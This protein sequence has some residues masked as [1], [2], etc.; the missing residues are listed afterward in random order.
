MKQPSDQL[1][2]D[3]IKVLSGEVSQWTLNNSDCYPRVRLWLRYVEE[4]TGLTKA[5]VLAMIETS[6]Y[7]WMPHLQESI[8]DKIMETAKA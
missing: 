6:R 8:L 1:V 5:D 7:P 4:Q 2:L 3:T